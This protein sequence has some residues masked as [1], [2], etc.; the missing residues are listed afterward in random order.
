MEK[1]KT[2]LLPLWNFFS[3]KSL[4]IF[5]LVAASVY[6][7]MLTAWGGT[8]PNQVVINISYTLP[9]KALFAFFLLNNLF[10]TIK[11]VPLT[12]RACSVERKPP[13]LDWFFKRRFYTSL[14][15][16][17]D[18]TAVSQRVRSYLSPKGYRLFQSK[19]RKSLRAVKGRFAP[20]GSI[21]FHLSFFLIFAGI[22]SSFYTASWGD[23]VLTE[24]QSFFGRKD[25]YIRF[26]PRAK[27]SER[28]PK[29]SFSIEKIVPQFWGRKVL[30]T[31]L[32]A[33]LN[34]PAGASSPKSATTRLNVPFKADFFTYISITGMGYSPFYRLKE[35]GG[36]ELD[37]AFV[38]LVTFPP[39]SED[40]F[41]LRETPY[42]VFVQVYPDYLL[43]K[44]KLSTQSNDLKNPAYYV[45]IKR[46]K[47][48]VFSGVLLPQEEAKFD[49]LALSFPEIKYWGQLRIIRNKGLFLI[50]AG[51]IGGII[52]LLWRLLVTRKEIVLLM[53]PGAGTTLHLTC[54][55]E[56]YPH[57]QAEELEGLVQRL[58]GGR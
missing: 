50:F 56:Y 40:S 24:G 36:Q 26:S 23:V 38:T 18:V 48:K 6:G 5:L 43:Q 31:D 46:N 57:L 29:I 12:L 49:G 28:S 33:H 14:E 34:Y 2:V 37:S 8:S 25:E 30:F 3:S 11:S 4:N 47:E 13:L 1:V 39:G 21:F 52:G 19:D 20:L 27:F 44:G 53:I 17:Q 9:F 32:Y 16:S 7:I 41:V 10:C 42:K 55:S 54:S 45:E 51:Y 15:V 22:I 58:K 35:K